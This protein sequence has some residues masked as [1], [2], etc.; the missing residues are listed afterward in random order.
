MNKTQLAHKLNL[1]EK[2]I[3]RILNP[4][5][6]TKLSTIEQVLLALG[7]KIDVRIV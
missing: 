1:D 3:R 4:R 5:H 7:K 2:E 6:G